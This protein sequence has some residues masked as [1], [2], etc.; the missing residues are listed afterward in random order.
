MIRAFVFDLG[1]VLIRILPERIFQSWGEQ[2]GLDWRE[3]HARFRF[4]EVHDAFERGEVAPAQFLA[5]IRQTYD[6]PLTDAQLEQGWNA[7]FVGEVPGVTGLIRAL[8]SHYRVVA[9]SNT[10]AIHVPFFKAA[11]EETLRDLEY[12]FA[13]NEI[14]TRKPEA[15]AYQTVMDYLQMRPEELV[16]LDDNAANVRAARAIGMQAIEFTAVD[17]ALAELR[18]IGID[19]TQAS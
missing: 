16:F 10:N 14:G 6:L 11:Y 15:Q 9:L 13:S 12:V 7:I 4:D 8:K 2:S 1:N 5:H 17:E 18:K 3:I 19:Q